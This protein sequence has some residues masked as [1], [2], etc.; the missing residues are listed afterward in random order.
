MYNLSDLPKRVEEKIQ[1]EPKEGRLMADY[2]IVTWDGSNTEAVVELAQRVANLGCWPPASGSLT[3]EVRGWD[4]M[5]PGLNIANQ[6]GEIIARVEEGNALVFHLF[7]P[8]RD[9]TPLFAA[10]PDTVAAFYGA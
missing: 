9:D 10:T 3:Y 5:H 1:P 8:G 6:A 4:D 7:R 2:E